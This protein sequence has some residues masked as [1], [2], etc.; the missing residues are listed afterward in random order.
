MSDV[1]LRLDNLENQVGQLQN[2]NMALRFDRIADRM[3]NERLKEEL[4]E[5]KQMICLLSLQKAFQEGR[6]KPGLNI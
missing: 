4:K 6:L 3:E 2:Q 5:Q 1:F